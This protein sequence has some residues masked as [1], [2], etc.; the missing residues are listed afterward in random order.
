MN[1]RITWGQLDQVASEINAIERRSIRVCD[2]GENI[3]AGKE[4]PKTEEGAK[5]ALG[6]LEST[7]EKAKASRR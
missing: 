4:F 2:H 3:Y 1:K 6:F 7:L 5:Q